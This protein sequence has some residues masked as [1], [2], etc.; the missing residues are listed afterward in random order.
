MTSAVY[1][2]DFSRSLKTLAVDED[3]SFARQMIDAPELATNAI[4]T[5]HRISAEQI[6]AEQFLQ[7]PR[8]DRTIHARPVFHF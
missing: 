4:E 5:A 6:N 3:F 1:Q 8:I 7:P 2:T